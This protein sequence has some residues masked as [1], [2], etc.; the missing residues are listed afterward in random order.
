MANQTRRIAHT[1]SWSVLAA[2]VVA[3]VA[4]PVH[5]AP[6]AQAAPHAALPAITHAAP[7]MT[8]GS[9]TSQDIVHRYW[10]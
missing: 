9:G 6:V 2:L 7:G 5:Q 1:G 3:S 8:T 10:P 4:A